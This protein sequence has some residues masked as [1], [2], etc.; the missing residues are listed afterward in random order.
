MRLVRV[1]AWLGRRPG[2]DVKILELTATGALIQNQGTRSC[3]CGITATVGDAEVEC[4]PAIVDLLPNA[5]PT[6][7]RIHGPEPLRVELTLRVNDG[8]RVTIATHTADS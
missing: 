5:Q 3:R 6:R 1:P 2:P 7:I 8:K 4:S